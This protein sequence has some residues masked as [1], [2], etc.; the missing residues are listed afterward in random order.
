MYRDLDRAQE[1]DRTHAGHWTLD[2]GLHGAAAVE[3]AG[4]LPVTAR[5]IRGSCPDVHVLWL[6]RP[7]DCYLALM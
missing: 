7:W 1:R 6:D 4:R 2:R 3:H 5:Q